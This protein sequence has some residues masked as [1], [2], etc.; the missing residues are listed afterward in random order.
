MRC[1]LFVKRRALRRRRTSDRGMPS[2][3]ESAPGEGEKGKKPPRVEL[4][5]EFV[6][7]LANPTYIHCT[8]LF[9][10][11]SFRLTCQG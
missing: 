5:L 10:V 9:L 6:Q 8:V 3:V 1:P 7:C 2:D 4:E 11:L